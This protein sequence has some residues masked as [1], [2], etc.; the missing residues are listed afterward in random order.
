[1]S[2]DNKK[3]AA[4]TRSLGELGK[5]FAIKALV[6]QGF[7]G[8]KIIYDSNFNEPFADL[9]CEKNGIRYIITVKTRNKLQQNG[10]LNKS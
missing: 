5:L 10:S 6:D 7:K 2:V 9:L 1:M 4:R 8:I 3:N